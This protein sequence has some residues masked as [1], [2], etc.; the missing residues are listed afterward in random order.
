MLTAHGITASGMASGLSQSDSSKLRCA[1]NREHARSML[2]DQLQ[3]EVKAR[4]CGEAVLE[5]AGSDSSFAR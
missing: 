3:E 1:A 2:F 4:G 5:N